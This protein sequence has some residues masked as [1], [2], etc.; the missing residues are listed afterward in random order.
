MGV[1][2]FEYLSDVGNQLTREA[3][4]V[5]DNYL[6]KW[7]FDNMENPSYEEAFKRE[8]DRDVWRTWYKAIST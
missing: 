3:R 8:I 7:D 6:D 4:R 2:Q 5:L 1:T